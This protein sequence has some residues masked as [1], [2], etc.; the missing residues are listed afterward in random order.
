MPFFDHFHPPLYW[1]SYYSNW[2]TRIADGIAA[3]LPPE[4]QVE[5]HKYAGRR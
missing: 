3:V 5:E 2:A 1:G 4:C